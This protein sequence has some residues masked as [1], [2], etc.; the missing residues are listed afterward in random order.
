MGS[1][2][3]AP[4]LRSLPPL[5]SHPFPHAYRGG[6]SIPGRRGLL[7][8]IIKFFLVSFVWMLMVVDIRLI[9]GAW[10]DLNS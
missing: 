2:A 3:Q 6:P 9:I 7:H 1:K 10:S 4:F 8:H 5:L